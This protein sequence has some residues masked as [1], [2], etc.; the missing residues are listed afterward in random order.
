[1]QRQLRELRRNAPREFGRALYEEA[2]VE[3]TEA[4]RRVPVDTGTLRASGDVSEPFIEGGG[5]KV[6]M[7]FGD[8]G[9]EQYAI[10]VHEDLDA[11]H[12]VGQAKY[13]ES[14]LMESAP[15][16]AERVARRI[17]LNRMKG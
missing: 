9:A 16:M 6:V 8:P 1:M 7:S 4:K 14:V 13:L 2:Q 10:I 11:F 5:P 12:K 17:D 3:M 15:H